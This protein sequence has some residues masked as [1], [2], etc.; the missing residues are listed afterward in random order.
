MRSALSTGLQPH[1]TAPAAG[2]LDDLARARIRRQLADRFGDLPALSAHVSLLDARGA[3]YAARAM[4]AWPAHAGDAF[5]GVIRH[6]VRTQLP[7]P[8]PDPD[9]ESWLA[10]GRPADP[11]LAGAWDELNAL[12][13]PPGRR[14]QPRHRDPRVSDTV[15]ALDDTLRRWPAGQ[16]D[17]FTMAYAKLEYVLERREITLPPIDR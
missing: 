14:L 7:G 3:W 8:P 6:V 15:I 1:G 11:G 10:S 12:R 17:A 2:P 13:Y 5:F 9:L 16:F 4:T